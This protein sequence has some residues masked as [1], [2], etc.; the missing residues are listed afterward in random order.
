MAHL[1]K[2]ILGI[3]LTV[4]GLVAGRLLA[5]A[6]LAGAASAHEG[7]A[8]AHDDGPKVLSPQ[9]LKS[10]GV[11]VGTAERGD[12][13]LTT[14]VQAVV[15][16]RPLNQRPVVAPLGGIVTRVEV[17]TGAVAAAGE[18]LL[19]IAR[20]PIARPKPE[21]TADLLKPISEDVH[22]T[23]AR[24]RLARSEIEVTKQELDRIAPFVKNRTIPGKTAIDLRYQLARSEQELRNAGTELKAHGLTPE[25]IDAVAGGAAPPRTPSLWRRTL[26][27]NGLWTSDSEALWTAIPEP[28]RALPWCVAAVGELTAAGL[29]SPEVATF[30]GKAPGATARFAE[31]AGLLLEGTPLETVRLLLSVGAL[32]PEILVRAPRNG[33]PDWDIEE[34][35]TR[36][37]RHVEAGETVVRLYDARVM[38]LRLQ[39]LGREIGLVAR[40]IEA[41]VP[42]RATPLIEDSG[43]VLDAVRL[44]RLAM[45]GEDGDRGGLAH[46]VVEN[47]PLA[48]AP[49]IPCRSWELRVGLRYL[50][51]VPIER[52][53]RRFVLPADAI[54]QRGPDRLVFLQNGDTFRAQPVHVEYADEKIAVVADDGSIYEGDPV[55]L[56]G[57]F[58]LGLALDTGPAQADPHAGH[59]HN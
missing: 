29:V 4:I 32:E 21:L 45:Q 47:V 41:G 35:T 43:P 30:V 13:V 18:V 26:Q 14:K 25:E 50:V 23:A 58:S 7:E 59:N 12:F 2:I 3:V 11:E 33:A 16:D 48:C 56:R 44:Q 20:D 55:V 53:E 6:P 5:E 49:G 19:A 42:L 38:W 51:E 27:E 37:G 46:A 15:T 8:A 17:Q 54:A 10:L 28:Q 34:I 1:S 39:P 24:L 57:A 31:I 9:T 22:E 36:V 40:A 52:W